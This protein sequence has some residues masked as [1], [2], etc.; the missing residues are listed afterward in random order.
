MIFS[1]KKLKIYKLLLIFMQYQEICSIERLTE[2]I[3]MLALIKCHVISLFP[4]HLMSGNQNY[5][6]L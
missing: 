6:F 4:K 1:K 5:D 3:K 2:N